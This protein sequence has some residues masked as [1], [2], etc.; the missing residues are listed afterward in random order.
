MV[1]SV[2][3]LGFVGLTTALGFAAHGHEV[4]GIESNEERYELLKSGKMP[5]FEPD[6]GECLER[7]L[8]NNLF[9]EKNQKEVINKCECVF[10]C[11]G[12]PVGEAGAA[13]LS[14]LVKAIEETLNNLHNV[15][16][17]TLVIKSTV[18]VGTM[19]NCVL[20]LLK[21]LGCTIN[22]N[23]DVA[24]NPEFLREGHC[25]EDFNNA[26]RIVI[27]ALTNN[28]FQTLEK[29]YKN[30]DAPIY[31]VNPT[32]AEFIKYLS[33]TFLA[34]MI[35]FSN[36]MANMAECVG[37]IEIGKA[38]KILHKDH[39]WKDDLMSSYVYPGCGY[40][41]YCLPKDTKAMM[42][43]GESF[44][45]KMPILR[46]V[47]ETNESMTDNIVKKIEKRLGKDESVGILGLAFKPFT[48]DVRETPA[49]KIILKLK[50][51][52][53]KQILVYDPIAMESFKKAYPTVDV[54]YCK[55]HEELVR[56]CKV[57][58]IVTAWPEFFGY[59]NHS[60]VLDLRYIDNFQ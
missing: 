20:P 12:T 17:I 22:E 57:S 8:G 49:F 56:H 11:V 31:K 46:S 52:G 13:E 23:I 25:W 58:V 15:R 44:G 48:D 2:I 36:E 32:T 5:F 38:F 50:E 3:G 40:G 28:A 42:C 59:V 16:K 19:C 1:I 35:S 4:Y 60:S 33:N 21:K 55:T 51:R 10:Y 37:D 6:F 54:K 26:D 18:P 45:A 7:H 39:R 47:I 27:G 29:I 41:G 9:I 30:F 14:Y 53:V 43:A 24:N 34:T